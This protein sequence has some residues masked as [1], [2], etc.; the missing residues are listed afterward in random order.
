M[1]GEG[2]G[3]DWISGWETYC[4]EAI[5]GGSWGAGCGANGSACDAGAE[6]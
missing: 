4:G 3:A 6:A 1:G 5:S 2:C